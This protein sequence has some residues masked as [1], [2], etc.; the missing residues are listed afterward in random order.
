MG[1]WFGMALVG[2]LCLGV[3]IVFGQD[4]TRLDYQKLVESADENE[5]GYVDRVE[6]MEQMTEAF[7][8]VDVDK[9]GYLTLDEIRQTAAKV[10]P[11]DVQ[12]ADRNGDG[13]LSIHEYREAVENDFDK[14]DMDDDGK[15]SPEEIRSFVP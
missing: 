7:F 3:V 2:S 15:L 10:D 12:A 4:A 8:I 5:D 11:K 9:D 1:R 14:A 13:K 6:F